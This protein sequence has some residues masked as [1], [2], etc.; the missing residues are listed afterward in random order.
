MEVISGQLQRPGFAPEDVK[1]RLYERKDEYDSVTVTATAY[2]LKAKKIVLVDD[3]T[4]G[5]IVTITL[6]AVIDNTDRI[7]YFKKL[8]TTANVILDGFGGETIDGATTK[9][10]TTQ[11]ESTALIC[12]GAEWFVF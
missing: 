9:T 11:Y 6:P 8:G 3:D 5:G 10:L 4:A 7:V 1:L 2:T 12:S